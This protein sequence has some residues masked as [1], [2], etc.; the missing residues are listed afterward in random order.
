MEDQGIDLKYLELI[1]EDYNEDT[2]IATKSKLEVMIEI[3]KL[4]KVLIDKVKPCDPVS[5]RSLKFN[6]KVQSPSR[7]NL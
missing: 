1:S 5:A 6:R 3:T 2:N 7:L 4:Q